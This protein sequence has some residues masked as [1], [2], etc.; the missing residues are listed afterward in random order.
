MKE[1]FYGCTNLLISASDIPNLKNVTDISSMFSG[2]RVFNQDI[3]NWD[4]SSV[5][6]MSYM[7]LEAKAFN[8]DIRN[9]DVSSIPNDYNKHNFIYKP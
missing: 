6:N 9:W 5:T 1:S 2:A 3:G 7:F 4:V 8:Q